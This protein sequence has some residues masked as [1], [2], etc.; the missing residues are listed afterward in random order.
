MPHE[1]VWAGTSSLFFTFLLSEFVITGSL[2]VTMSG[3][4]KQYFFLEAGSTYRELIRIES[5]FCVR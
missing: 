5:S 1:K 2:C 3:E 4:T